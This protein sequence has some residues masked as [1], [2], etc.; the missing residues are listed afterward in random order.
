VAALREGMSGLAGRVGDGVIL[1]WLSSE[2]VRAV[3]PLARAGGEGKETV[4]PQR[5]RDCRSDR[6]TA[7]GPRLSLR[8]WHRSGPEAVAYESELQ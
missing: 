2:E 5:A 7:A 1:N 3:A 4:A 8:S 6:G